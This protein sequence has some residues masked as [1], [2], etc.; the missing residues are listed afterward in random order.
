MEHAGSMFGMSFRQKPRRGQVRVLEALE[1]HTA[2]LNIKFP[3]GYGKTYTAALVYSFLKKQ[4]KV[5]R[6]LVI[7]P[8]DGQLEQFIKD[9]PADLANAGVEGSLQIDDVRFFGKDS[10]L[11]HR[12]N[13]RQ[14]FAITIQSL[15]QSRGANAV[16][17][18]LQNGQW[19]ICVDEYHHYGIEKEWG[20]TVLALPRQFLL[21]MSATPL[22]PHDDSAFGKPHISVSYR[23]AVEE[24][25]QAVKPLRGHSYNYKV[26]AILD[27]GEVVSFTTSELAEQAGGDDPDKIEKLRIERKMRWSPKY[28]SPL[29]SVPIER[30]LRERIATGYRL[31]ALVGAM[32]VSHADLVCSQLRTMFP[33][34]AI[35]WVGTGKHGRPQDENRGIL[36]KYCPQKDHDGV[37]HPTLDVLVHVGMAGEGLDSI[38]VSEVVSLHNASLCNQEVQ[39]IGRAARYLPDVTGNINFDS[40]SEF[41]KKKYV[42]QAIMDAMDYELPTS[43]PPEPG[44]EGDDPEPLPEEPLIRIYDMSLLHIDSGSAEVRRMADVLQDTGVNGIDYDAL[45]GDQRHP[46]WEKVCNAY[47]VMRSREAQAFNEK[48]TV[49][50]WYESV[51]Y[52][53]SSV[54]S[55]VRRMRRRNGLRDEKSLQGDLK[56]RINQRKASL[57]G[58]IAP[59]VALC[60]QH[61]RWVQQLDAEIRQHGIPAWLS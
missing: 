2:I 11:K 14:I 1:T 38:H 42:G 5:T 33:E 34:L 54:A 46:H 35:D 48:A 57:F 37:R 43:K 27:D 50:Q 25:P 8:T 7:F 28:V 32:C 58:K 23:E 45:R 30:M 40:S 60:Q 36:D 41:A 51:D 15:I 55:L 61:Y 53:V 4:G 47:L 19:M 21:A 29:V 52:A 6:L 16:G 3:T 39:E 10:L 56:K 59:N 44:E 24:D 49:K 31:Q 17:D 22:R 20:R 13:E 26:D 12:R 9:G 18:L